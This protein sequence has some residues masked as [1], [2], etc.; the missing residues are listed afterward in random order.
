MNDS[1]LLH[2]NALLAATLTVFYA[3]WWYSLGAPLT[4]WPL[5][6]FA[7]AAG[8]LVLLIP[9]LWR[10]RR[11][12]TTLAGFI[13]PF[14]FAYGVMEMVANPAMRGWAALQAAMALVLFVT[15]MASLKQ[16]RTA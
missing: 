1:P 11:F 4:A 8:S 14:H 6:V 7:V 16:V 2:V 3:I 9:P 12:G 13:V 15:V 10:G 5:A